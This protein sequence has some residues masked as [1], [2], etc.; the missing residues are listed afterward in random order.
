MFLG[1]CLEIELQW[2]MQSEI[3]T[4]GEGQVDCIND[5]LRPTSKGTALHH[6]DVPHECHSWVDVASFNAKLVWRS[7]FPRYCRNACGMLL[8]ART[9]GVT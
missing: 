1:C 5:R 2:E 9:S 6:G 8:T 4:W 3:T 7:L